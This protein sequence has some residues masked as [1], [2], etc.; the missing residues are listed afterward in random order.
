MPTKRH[1]FAYLRMFAGKKSATQ[2]AAPRRTPM[3]ESNRERSED[4]TF[5]IILI[6]ASA[7]WAAVGFY[8]I[9]AL[10]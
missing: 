10:I 4:R 2:E 9:H 5:W 3:S 1:N 6:A 7:A 8:I